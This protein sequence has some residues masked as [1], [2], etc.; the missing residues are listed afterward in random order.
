MNTIIMHYYVP[1]VEKSGDD[2]DQTE[3]PFK[4]IKVEKSTEPNESIFTESSQGI[5]FIFQ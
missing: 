4:R 5:I 3:P 1:C 2:K